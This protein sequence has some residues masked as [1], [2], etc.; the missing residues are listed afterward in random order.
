M[1]QF[2]TYPAYPMQ[3]SCASHNPLDST[4]Y[5]FGSLPAAAP[6]TTGDLYRVYIPR[7]GHIRKF[8]VIVLVGGT[9]GSSET[10][11]MYLRI[12]GTTDYLIS[13]AMSWAS[14]LQSVAEAYEDDTAPAVSINDYFEIKFITPAWVTNPTTVIYWGIMWIEA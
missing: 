13:S 10:G 12:N 8:A 14:V 3:F 7:T 11:T 1:E 9:L 5:Y 6:T 4:T 2:S